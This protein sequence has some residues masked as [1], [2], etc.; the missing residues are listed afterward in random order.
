MALVRL[1]DIFGILLHK[2][3]ANAYRRVVKPPYKEN[4][5]CLLSDKHYVPFYLAII[6]TVFWILV[7]T[8]YFY[9]TLYDAYKDTRNFTF[10]TSFYFTMVTFMTIGSGEFAPI[11]YNLIFPNLIF[12]LIGLSLLALCI[13]IIQRKIEYLFNS[14]TDKI[15]GI[16]NHSAS[17]DTETNGRR[18][19]GKPLSQFKSHQPIA[20][21]TNIRKPKSAKRKE[22]VLLMLDEECQVDLDSNNCYKNWAVRKSDEQGQKVAG[23]VK[24]RY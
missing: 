11:V 1:G 2:L 21:L 19:N 16:R 18:K 3:W 24:Q 12:I 6:V 20:V 13:N 15:D 10:F 9:L 17:Y 14:F 4:S 22:S 5:I 7:C 8:T 23:S